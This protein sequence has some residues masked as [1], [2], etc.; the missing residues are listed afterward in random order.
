MVWKKK[1]QSH[2]TSIPCRHSESH[3]NP[4]RC[5]AICYRFPGHMNRRSLPASAPPFQSHNR[6]YPTGKR[7]TK[8]YKTCT[9]AQQIIYRHISSYIRELRARL[10]QKRHGTSY[11][12]SQKDKAAHTNKTSP[13]AAHIP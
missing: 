11:V 10:S 3:S 1:L 7:P 2:N 13:A 4:R 5:N 8:I 12:I 9:R 6:T